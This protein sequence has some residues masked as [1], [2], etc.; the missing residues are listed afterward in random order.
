MTNMDGTTGARKYRTIGARY[1][2]GRHGQS[3]RAMAY[4]ICIL[5][6]HQPDFHGDHPGV[7]KAILAAC[8]SWFELGV[9]GFR[10][11]VFNCYAKAEGYPN[12]PPHP[13][14][15]RRL[16]GIAPHVGQAHIYDRDVPI[17]HDYLAELRSLA[18]SYDAVL[19]G[20]TLDEAFQ[21]DKASSYVND[22]ACMGHFRLLHSKW[23]AQP[24]K[25]AIQAW[26]EALEEGRLP[27]WAL[28]NHDFSSTWYALGERSGEGALALLFML[29][30]V[31]VLYNGDEL[32]NATVA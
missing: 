24:F 1:L 18:D 6:R 3:I 14:W 31:P 27:V 4:I 23:S 15:W 16:G 8:Q 26:V 12:N 11:D 2:A 29:P 22:K 20:E 5:D 32:R 28:S 7:R 19:L 9:S 30:G 13:V 21:Y 17:L 10:L 25:E